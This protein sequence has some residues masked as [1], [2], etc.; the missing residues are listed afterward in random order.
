[1]SEKVRK[2][3]PVNY[4]YRSIVRLTPRQHENLLS[5]CQEWGYTLSE[6]TRKCLQIVSEMSKEERTKRWMRSKGEKDE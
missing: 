5:L 1:M 4:H 2:K 6:T 3:P